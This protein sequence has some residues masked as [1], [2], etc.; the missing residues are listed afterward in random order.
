MSGEL[1]EVLGRH[2]ALW[3]GRGLPRREARA[4]R[5]GFPGLDA[6]LPGGGWPSG[7]LVDI[8]SAHRGIGELSILLPAMAGLCRKGLHAVWIDPP[9]TPYAP[10][11]QQAGVITQQVLVIGPCPSDGDVPWCMEKIL[12]SAGCGM[13]LAWPGRLDF[14]TAR[15]LQL[16]AESGGSLGVLFRGPDPGNSPAA[17]R[18]GLTPQGDTLEVGI[19]KARG[20][21]GR[22]ILRLAL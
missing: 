9:F 5:T 14:R 21:L 10:A 16:A 13:A 15:R 19:L 4:I 7:A 2:P 22:A 20:T 12:Y 18:L 17:L 8:V 11:L 6:A 3:R 1:E